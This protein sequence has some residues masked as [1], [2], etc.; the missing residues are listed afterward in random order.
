M[1]ENKP[2]RAELNR[3]LFLRAFARFAEGNVEALRE[4]LAED[5]LDHS[6][7]NPSGRD[8]F[9][10]FVAASPT[11]GA[12][13]ELARVVADDQY[14]VAHYRMTPAAG[15]DAVAVVDIWRLEDGLITEHWD[16]VQPVP[17]PA[18]TPNGMF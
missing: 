11:A 12:R 13:L 15:E 3:K 10:E 18:L 5:F 8:A 4:V 9:V 2:T 14:V 16:V 6:P 1:S 17:E 7:G